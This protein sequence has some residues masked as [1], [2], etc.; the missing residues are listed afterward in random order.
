M[1]S[2]FELENELKSAIP[3]FGIVPMRR[4]AKRRA[5]A[6]AAPRPSPLARGASRSVSFDAVD[7]RVPGIVPQLRQPSS[8]T[9]WATV[10]TMMTSWRD[11]ASMTIERALGL[12]GQQWVDKFG[13]N[14]GLSSAEK[15]PFL[16]AAGL[17]AEPP[18]SYSLEGWERLLRTYGPLWVTT[19]EQPGAGFAIHARVIAGM[20]GDG[21]PGGTYFDIVD[22]GTGTEYTERFADFLT[23]YEE[24]A[25]DPNRP[26]RIQVVHWPASAMST[27]RSYGRFSRARDA[28]TVGAV[29]AVGALGYNIVR[30]AVLSQGDISFQLSRMEG[31][32]APNDDRSYDHRAAYQT[33]RT[34]VFAEMTTLGGGDISARFEMEFNYNGHCVAN[35][36]MQNI[37]TDDAFGWRLQVST[38]TIQDAMVYRIGSVQPVAAVKVSFRYGFTHPIYQDQIYIEDLVLYGTGAIDRRRRWTQSGA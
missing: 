8:M 33:Q 14:E 6:P 21:T 16:A 37:N 26:L 18:M 27:Q 22:P 19:D 36:R 10:T 13:R 9:C 15:A 1:P 29:T 38:D 12:A 11:S 2:I 30:D 34:E 7:F 23:K 4:S 5:P 17:V 31:I 24:E 25:L 20:H 3:P 35:V 32:K 28:A